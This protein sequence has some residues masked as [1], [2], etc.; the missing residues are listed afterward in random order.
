MNRYK[1]STFANIVK[2]FS[3]KKIMVIGDLLLD[4]FVWGKVSRIS[5]EAP[6][7]V[8]WVEDESYMPGGACNVAS[9]LVK[10][11]AQ[12]SLVGVAG[13]KKKDEKAKI[14]LGL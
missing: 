14:L 6:V 10:L 11:G 8:V 1:Y 4:Q 5:P 3:R 7:P 9:N 2:R 12:V 13:D